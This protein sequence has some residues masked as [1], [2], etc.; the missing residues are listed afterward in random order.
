M[1]RARGYG[2]EKGLFMTLHLAREILGADVPQEVLDGLR[3]DDF[4]TTI[5]E[6]ARMQILT[7]KTAADEVPQSVA[8]VLSGKG[9]RGKME[10]IRKSSFP[11]RMELANRHG[12]S[13]SSVLLPYYY[14][15]HIVKVIGRRASALFR[16]FFGGK[17]SKAVY[18]RRSSIQQWLE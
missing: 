16:V 8:S 13:D 11:S 14:L 4:D 10:R 6:H 15:R 2:W 7:G 12:V 3:P 18:R 1:H 17:D 9:L 5:A